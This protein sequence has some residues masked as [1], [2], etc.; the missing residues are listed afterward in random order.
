MFLPLQSLACAYNEVYQSQVQ[1]DFWGLREFYSTVR[2]INRALAVDSDGT[3]RLL[4][5]RVVMNA[6]QRNFGGKPAE[7]DQVVSVFFNSLGLSI[8]GVPRSSVVE[9]V[10]ENVKSPEARHLM[11]LTKNNAA[12]G[13]L[14]DYD[15]LHYERTD[16]IFGSDFPLDQTDLQICLNIQRIKLCM[17][18]GITVVLVHCES[19]YESLYDLLNQHY[20]EYGGQLY[21]RLAFGTHSR[22]CPIHK[23]FRIVV[24]VEKVEAYTRL[25]P[26]LLNRFEKQ[27]ME[28]QHLL[29]DAQA[30]MVTR[31]LDFAELLSQRISDKLAATAHTAGSSSSSSYVDAAATVQQQNQQNLGFR[32][33]RLAFC[34]WH[35]ELLASLVQSLPVDDPA[36]PDADSRFQELLRRLLWLATPESVCRLLGQPAKLR[37]LQERHRVDL[38]EVYFGQQHHADLA[39]FCANMLPAWAQN[40][41]RPAHAAG[42]T[43][44]TMTTLLTF[45]PFSMRAGDVI[46]TETQWKDVQVTALHDLSSERDLVGRLNDFFERDPKDGSVFLLQCDPLAASLRRIEQ[47]NLIP[48][49]LYTLIPLYPYTLIPSPFTLHPSP[50]TLHPS[51]LTQAKYLCNNARVRWAKRRR[52][53]ERKRRREEE[54]DSSTTTTTVATAEGESD[55]KTTPPV[56][57][58][59]E[60]SDESNTAAAAAATAAAAA[61]AAAAT[62]AAAAA[63]A[64]ATRGVHIVFFVHLSRSESYAFDFDRRWHLAYIDSIEPAKSTGLPSIQG[65][66]GRS[67]SEIIGSVDLAQVLV[68][69]FRAAMARLVFNHERTNDDVREQIHFLLRTLQRDKAFVEA[70]MCEIRALVH[71]AAVTLNVLEAAQQEEQLVLGGTFQSALHRQIVHMVSASFALLLAHFD[72]NGNSFLLDDPDAE[73]HAIWLYLFRRSVD[74]L[75]LALRF[76]ANAR[77]VEVG[78]DGTGGHAFR[79]AFP[80][81]F[82]VCGLLQA[83]KPSVES[84]GLQM[85]AGLQEQFKLLKLEQRLSDRLKVDLMQRYVADFCSMQALHAHSLSPVSFGPVL[86]HSTIPPPHTT[87]TH[88]F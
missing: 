11:V 17:A 3:S 48:L 28:R 71:H 57:A 18:E 50:F 55:G 29:S 33:L 7:M 16:I 24:V 86:H 20:T 42:P 68:R 45:S 13:L 65:M 41:R 56:P 80:F 14:F 54:P 36:F 52:E 2:H 60:S 78:S 22:L 44:C 74:D 73:V 82:F 12:L 75:R 84:M 15:I 66:L 81:S 34:G 26:P 72:R 46:R 59:G 35:G 4:D 85:E 9:L 5:G 6:V 30:S 10:S 70:V 38:Q 53:E 63:A 32:S 58:E 62:A 37:I 76:N 79:A 25:A 67:M 64:A 61:A 27:V 87:H 69:T 31:L 1:A 23:N 43:D 8:M 19:L 39:S 21:V 40:E 77:A 88:H 51:P 49:Y 83:L 47:A